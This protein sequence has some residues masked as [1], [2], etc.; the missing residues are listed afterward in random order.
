MKVPY[1]FP[2]EQNVTERGLTLRDWFAGQAISKAVELGGWD[3][4][5]YAM[6]ADKRFDARRTRQGASMSAHPIPSLAR[7]ALILLFIVIAGVGLAT[8]PEINIAYAGEN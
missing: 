7:I 1:F 8:E 5:G 6:P 2:N 4:D 3:S